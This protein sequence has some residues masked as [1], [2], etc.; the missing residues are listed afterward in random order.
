[1]T[2]QHRPNAPEGG[3][4]RRRALQGSLAAGS[5]LVLPGV[6]AACGDDGGDSTAAGVPEGTRTVG[7][8]GAPR[9]GGR[10]RVGHV[11]G[12]T[13]ETLDPNSGIVGIDV[14]RARQLYELLFDFDP[15]GVAQPRL[16]E[17]LE[18]GAR[19]DRWALRLRAG[20]T[21]QD[22]SPLRADDV[23]FTWK[24]IQGRAL[25]SANA[26]SAID[27][28]RTKKR[29][30]TEIDVVLTRPIGD[31]ASLLAHRASF[32]IKAG[33]TDFA[34]PNG[35]GPFALVSFKP[36]QR[37][38]MRRN[39]G[40]WGDPAW[41][42]ELELISIPDSTARYNALQ[43]GQVDAI[44]AIE[45]AQARQIGASTTGPVRLVRTP[46]ASALP[47]YM[48]IDEQPF[49]DVRVRQAMRLAVDR[50]QSVSAALLGFGSVG[51]DLF[52]KGYPSYD[53]ALPQRAYDPEQARSLLKAAGQENLQVKLYTSRA[54]P[55]MLEAATAYKQQAQAAGISIDLQTVPASDYYSDRYYMK[56]AFGQDQWSGSFEQ[57]SLDGMLPES[58]FNITAW[59]DAAWQ[60]RFAEAQSLLDADR[61]NAVYK[62]LQRT[63]YD[64]GGLIVWGYVDFLDAVSPRVNGLAT[65][66]LYNLGYYEF[67]SWWLA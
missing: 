43:G 55:G 64:E 52:G 21:F 56:V 60:K 4:T 36:G 39:E 24:R 15:R 46:N 58:G 57:T 16:A 53:D 27:L 12:G 13:A 42:D 31:L 9:R 17:T 29:S 26:I 2:D 44:E 38:L 59:R 66:P 41:V 25:Q 40:Y 32:V 6:L 49:D 5:L 37:S 22:G 48:R 67:R 65:N 20:V 63:L 7:G 61:R 45:F 35:T 19:P 8:G 30:D 3:L 33:T 51:N 62:E 34:R 14:A 11:G 50:E 47:T 1:V 54:V 10:L 23:L 28:R 18:P